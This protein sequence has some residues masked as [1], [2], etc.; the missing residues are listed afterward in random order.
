MSDLYTSPGSLSPLTRARAGDIN[1][2]ESAVL[3]AF[4][5]LPNEAQVKGS[6]QNYTTDIGAVNAYVVTTPYSFLSYF[7]GM[8]I[9]FRTANT[10]TGAVT[11]NVNSLGV[12]S[13]KF[14][15][16][17]DPDSGTILAGSILSL[18]Y[19]NANGYF[20]FASPFQVAGSLSIST[21]ILPLV[22]VT[23][24]TNAVANT[25]EYAFTANGIL[26]LPTGIAG[27]VVPFRL[28]RGPAT[29][30]AC[31]LAATGGQP[32]M[33]LVESYTLDIPFMSGIARY[34]DATWGWHI[35]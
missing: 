16:G 32:I 33:G 31:S 4:T 17:A 7:D 34:I 35:G 26:T 20:V 27:S 1:A 29:L 2:R 6:T 14:P 25:N 30:T 5:K 10:N 15:G 11:I 22:L 12:K 18:R 23:G 3:A 24:N 21:S 19:D 13:V 9:V 28:A 8:E